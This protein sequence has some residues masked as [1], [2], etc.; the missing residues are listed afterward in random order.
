MD[1]IEVVQRRLAA[2]RL[3][4]P[5]FGSPAE[6]VRCLGA[7]QSQEYDQAL[8]ALAQRSGNPSAADVE[9][10][11]AAGEFVRTH[12]LRPTWHFVAAE[13]LGW[14]LRLTGPRLAKGDAGRLRQL[15]VTD[16]MVERAGEVAARAIA[17]SGPIT[18]QE[19]RERMAE[20]GIELTAAQI[21]HITFSHELRGL[22]CS[23][24]PRGAKQTYAL[25]ADRVREAREFDGEEALVE[26]ARRYFPSHGPAS[27]KDFAWWSGLNLTMARRAIEALGDALEEVEC[28]G[29]ALHLHRDSPEP[30]EIEG[31]LML[32]SFDELKVAF[33]G[34][35][36]VSRAGEPART[37]VLRPVLL[38]GRLA[39]SWK[40]VGDAEGVRIEF[41]LAGPA[42]AAEKAVL[43]AEAER[44][45][46]HLG[47][48]AEFA[49]AE[50]ELGA[51]A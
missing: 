16:A 46:A 10:A 37:L 15:E 38:D 6:A 21:G 26:L 42:G 4:G 43:A 5:G 25:V 45:A 13:D 18:R 39:G 12:V 20:D 17:G 27:A 40:R 7:V 30:R 48:P 19:W 32:G 29:E 23:G 24:P 36:T 31:A 1:A 33:R 9:A 44:Y 34:L 50:G 35:R 22:L 41:T 47:R 3:T 49:F 28:D 14:L 51:A 8:W 2:Q 11:F